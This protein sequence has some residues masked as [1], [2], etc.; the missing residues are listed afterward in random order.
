MKRLV[1]VMATLAC[2]I[3]LTMAPAPPAAADST[4]VEGPDWSV[5]LTFPNIQWTS[6]ACQFLPVTAVVKGSEVESWTFGGFVSLRGGDE[7]NSDWYIDYDARIR[8]G[9]GSFNVR[10]AVL[11]CPSSYDASA[12][13]DVVGEVGALLTGASDWTWLPYR[14]EFHVSGIPTSTTLDS[15]SLLGADAQVSGRVVATTPAKA[16][17]GCAGGSIEVEVLTDGEWNGI[18]YGEL[19]GDGDSFAVD[20]SI[21][22]LIGTQY[23]AT[24]DGGSVCADS[25]SAPRTLQ[26]RLP[27]ARVSAVRKQSK[28]K[29]DIDPNM[30]RRA[31]V[32]QVQRRTGDDEWKTLRTYRTKGSRETR[33][34]NLRKGYYRIHVAARFGYAETYSESVYLKR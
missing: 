5:S 25:S 9:A 15:I 1:A 2:M 16:F 17:Q 4:K 23:R 3:G 8:N 6:E 31:W 27:R 26:V 13:Y 32:F 19:E 20:V 24:L 34:I 10:H 11:V 21:S 12:T 33:T 22:Q 30:G 29:V 14:A 28:L 18:G 7:E